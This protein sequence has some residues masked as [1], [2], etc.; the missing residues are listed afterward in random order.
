MLQAD[1]HEL[2]ANQRI[3]VL[4]GAL[5][6]LAGCAPLQRES[7]APPPPP[8]LLGAEA[9]ELPAGCEPVTG[10]VYRTN[11]VVQPDGRVTDASSGH[12]EGCVEQALRSWVSSFRY[13][14]IDAQTPVVMDWL[15]VTATRGG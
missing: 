4:A 14:P 7:A 10:Q 8:Q 6:A 2:V 5:F 13:G 9:F 12:G 1:G 15:A 11:F 3:I